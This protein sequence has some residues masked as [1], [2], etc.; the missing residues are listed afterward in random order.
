MKGRLLARGL[1]VCGVAALVF[2]GSRRSVPVRADDAV[3]MRRASPHAGALTLRA[4]S[5]LD[6]QRALSRARR[7]GNQWVADDPAGR[8]IEF[9]V[10]PQLQERMQRLFAEYQV[11]HAAVVALDPSTGRVLAYASHSEDGAHRD[12]ARDV[13]APAA[14][15]FKLITSS[16]LFDAGVGPNTHVCYGGGSSRIMPIDLQDQ[17][18]RDRS[19]T[20]LEEALGKSTNAVF[21]K[22]ADRNL[23]PATLLRYARAFGFGHD[24]PFG[25]APPASPAEIPSNRLEFARTAA[26]FWHVFMSPLHAALIAAT[27]ANDGAM[28]EPWIVERVVT[29]TGETRELSRAGVSR[30]VLEPATARGVAHMMLRTVRDGTSRAAFQDGRGRPQLPGIAVAG[31]TGSLSTYDPYHAYSWWVGFAPADHPRIALAALIVNSPK[32]RIK[33]SFI[34]RE[35]LREYL[36]PQPGAD[37]L[38]QRKP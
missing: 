26:G 7:V 30:R 23:K 12:L 19:C 11:P 6:E 32:W 25:F 28:P 13:S 4:V 10:L 37:A 29:A 9:T 2:V 8:R 15:V 38:A 27:F 3:L 21:A 5:P 31:K 33:S 1:L 17:P 35:L 20:T 34:A 18:R 24:L 22:L 36:H 16:A 14:S